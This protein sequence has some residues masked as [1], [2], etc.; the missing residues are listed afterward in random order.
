MYIPKHFEQTNLEAMHELIRAYPFATLIT[1]SSDGLDVNHIPIHLSQEPRPYGLLS[2]HVNRTNPVWQETAD[3]MKATVVFQGPHAYITPSW[4]AS[5]SEHGQVVPTWNYTVVHAHGS[6]RVINDAEWLK[7]HL[8]LLTDQLE[9]PFPHP[10]SVADAPGDF[11]E[12]LLEHV[13]GIEITVDKLE[14][15]WKVSQNRQDRCGKRV[16]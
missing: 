4:Y 10:W 14:G 7:S 9:A 8:E 12:K 15:Q 13:V 11:T 2:G 3:V 5:K 16:V 1:S 6:M